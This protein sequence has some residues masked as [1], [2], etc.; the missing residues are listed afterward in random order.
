[1]KHSVKIILGVEELIS[2]AG[3][4]CADY[5]AKNSQ[6]QLMGGLPKITEIG[7]NLLNGKRALMLAISAMK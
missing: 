2:V 5:W 6:S 4:V 7:R 3:G 1:V